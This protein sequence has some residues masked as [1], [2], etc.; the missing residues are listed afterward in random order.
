MRNFAFRCEER[1]TSA[2]AVLRQN[3]QYSKGESRSALSHTA[4]SAVF[5]IFFP[6]DV[7]TSGAV[8]PNLPR[9]ASIRLREAQVFGTAPGSFT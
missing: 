3:C 9:D 1:R 5:P 7:V 6:S 8:N 4:P 2:S